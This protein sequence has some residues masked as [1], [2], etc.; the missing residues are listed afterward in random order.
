MTQ[1][2]KD[3][4]LSLLQ[5][6]SLPW[7]VHSVLAWESSHAAAIKKKKEEEARGKTNGKHSFL[8]YVLSTV[9]C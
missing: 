3:L 1:Q 5:L 7:C 8:G 9:V 2:V 6:S 4:V